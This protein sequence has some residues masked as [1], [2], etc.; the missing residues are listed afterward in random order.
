M[1]EI[2]LYIPMGGMIFDS[3]GKYWNIN[4]DSKPFEH[5]K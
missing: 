4:F 5:L 3:D 1:V 2:Y